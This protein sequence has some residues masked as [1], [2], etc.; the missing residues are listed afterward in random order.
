[1]SQNKMYN[2]QPM[3]W[4]AEEKSAGKIQKQWENINENVS[5]NKSKNESKE[6]EGFF[7]SMFSCL[8]TKSQKKHNLKEKY[9][10]NRRGKN[11]LIIINSLTIHHIKIY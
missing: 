9:E 6:K 2:K 1:M 11:I 8:F 3:I 7:R 5:V 4:G 10:M